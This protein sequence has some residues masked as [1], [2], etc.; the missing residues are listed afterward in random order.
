MGR[1]GVAWGPPPDPGQRQGPC[2]MPWGCILGGRPANRP[3]THI[4]VTASH[5]SG[6]PQGAA[7]GPFLMP[8]PPRS[9]P[10]SGPRRLSY[11]TPL[12]A[13]EPGPILSN[14]GRRARSRD[15]RRL[16]VSHSGGCQPASE[17][18][19][20]ALSEAE[21]NV[22]FEG[23]SRARPRPRR[24]GRSQMRVVISAIADSS[25]EHISAPIYLSWKIFSPTLLYRLRRL[26]FFWPIASWPSGRANRAI[27]RGCEVAQNTGFF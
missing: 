12:A 19:T 9:R 16:I 21:V 14:R 23:P 1:G 6:P 7:G 11:A 2:R 13:R 15:I 8:I 27:L 10:N 24:A 5:R 3:R 4:T 25:V 18:F 17:I 26:P 22:I 20:R